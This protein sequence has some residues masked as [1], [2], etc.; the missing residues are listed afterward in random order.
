MAVTIATG[1]RSGRRSS[2]RWVFDDGQGAARPQKSPRAV[3]A[4]DYTQASLDP[5]QGGSPYGACVL[6]R[7][8]IRHDRPAVRRVHETPGPGRGWQTEGSALSRVLRHT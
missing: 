7:S 6:L 2:P 1:L 4:S 3:D 5:A 8:H